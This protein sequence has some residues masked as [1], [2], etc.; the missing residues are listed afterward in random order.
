MNTKKYQRVLC[1]ALVCLSF[2]ACDLGW[3]TLGAAEYGVKFRI[4]PTFLGG[5][6]SGTIHR[7]GQMILVMPWES[8]YRFDTKIRTLEWGA[9]GPSSE[10]LGEDFVMTRA[11]DGNEVS[12]AVK[13]EYRLNTKPSELLHLIQNVGTSDAEVEQIVIA[14]ARADIRTQMNKLKTS[15]FFN[16]ESKYRGEAEVRAALQ[17]RLGRFG[18]EIISV[19]LKEH[20]FER[21][22]PDGQVDR[23]YQ[24]RIN[25]VQKKEQDTQREELRVATVTA[26]KQREFNDA[27]AKYN[28]H[29][30]EAEGVKKQAVLRADGYYKTKANEAEGILARGKAEAEGLKEQIAALAGSG[31]QEILKIEIAQELKK[32]EAKFF[33]L[34]SQ[35]SSGDL[36]LNKLD[37][38]ELLRQLGLIEGMKDSAPKR[39]AG[40]QKV[41]Q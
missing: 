41:K 31:G 21:V 28:R 16:N 39:A 9:K 14:S 12:L 35:G 2:S 36:R 30:A 15:E 38:N 11:L 13:I 29:L 37:S 1:L 6:L 10:R 17:K 23:S 18:I 32:S 5:G 27:K 34:E 25:E 24:E 3:R 22:L 33:A 4:L 40:E 26:D 8:L 20:R 7:P 19:N